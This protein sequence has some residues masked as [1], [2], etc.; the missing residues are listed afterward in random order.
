MKQDEISEAC[1]THGWNKKFVH[2]LIGKRVLTRDVVDR[3][4]ILIRN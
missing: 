2:I 4:K 1:S 3:R